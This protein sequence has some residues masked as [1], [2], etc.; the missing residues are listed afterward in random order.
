[1]EI[2]ANWDKNLYN[3]DDCFLFI[4]LKQRKSF[5]M[6]KN[7]HIVTFWTYKFIEIML[8]QVNTFSFKI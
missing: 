6:C 1:M 7:G 2:M 3:S 4:I 5:A 8:V